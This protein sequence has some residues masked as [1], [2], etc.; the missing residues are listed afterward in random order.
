MNEPTIE[1]PTSEDLENHI[2]LKKSFP[3][4][5]EA[6]LYELIFLWR[7]CIGKKGKLTYDDTW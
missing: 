5:R 6:H 4:G 2:I 7:I 1:K 3:D